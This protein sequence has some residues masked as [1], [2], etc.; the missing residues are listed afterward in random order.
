MSDG[1][2]MSA[3]DPAGAPFPVELRSYEMPLSAE[4]I[5]Q[6]RADDEVHAAAAP[7]IRDRLDADLLQAE[8]LTMHR[9]DPA[10][11][12]PEEGARFHVVRRED[13]EAAR[14]AGRDTVP[15][16]ASGTFGKAQRIMPDGRRFPLGDVTV[17]GL[18]PPAAD[19]PPFPGPPRDVTFKA[20]ASG[21][22]PEALAFMDELVATARAIEERENRRR[23]LDRIG[24]GAWLRPDDGLLEYD[25]VHDEWRVEVFTGWQ[26]ERTH[27]IRRYAG[28]HRPKAPRRRQWID[29]SRYLVDDG[30]GARAWFRPAADASSLTD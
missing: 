3:S 13:V 15:V 29:L 20:S 27:I 28:R 17:D 18:T 30:S 10:V 22:T 23:I 5:E 2:P 1:H 11:Q 8:P 24:V 14:A 16:V 7:L 12:R 6:I 19:G 21:M 4:R 9:V 25:E 26:R